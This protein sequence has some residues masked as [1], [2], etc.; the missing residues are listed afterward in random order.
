MPNTNRKLEIIIPKITRVIF[1]RLQR[2]AFN[3]N[4]IIFGGMVRDEIIATHYKNLFFKDLKNRCDYKKFWNEE[5]CPETAARTLIP[6]DMDVSF[7]S[8]EDKE[9]FIQLAID[10]FRENDGDF[11]YNMDEI[12]PANR[13]EIGTGGIQ[14]IQRLTFSVRLGKIPFVFRGYDINIQIDV[15]LAVSS[16]M[17]PP[18]KNLDMLSNSFIM[19]KH[20]K[21]LSR[22]TGTCLDNLTDLEH[23]IV[24]AKIMED[25]VNF[26]TDLSLGERLIVKQG[27]FQHNKYAFKRIDK[28]L[29]KNHWNIQNLPFKIHVFPKKDE[30]AKKEECCICCANFA[31]DRR[32][33]SVIAN[34][35]ESSIMHQNCFFRYIDH[36]INEFEEDYANDPLDT[37]AFKCPVRH[38]ID[39]IACSDTIQSKIDD[40]LGKK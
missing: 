22:F 29:S 19:T 8:F 23:A 5:F 37:Y 18:F 33:L 6:R 28:M 26:R 24:S 3:N 36:Q 14:S 35:V 31:S 39:F 25:I 13:Y 1:H 16:K 21:M 11:V 9:K 17:L 12:L 40:W 38:P 7:N 32:K 20:G 30:N 2:V 4:G 34:N 27:S 15:V 10:L